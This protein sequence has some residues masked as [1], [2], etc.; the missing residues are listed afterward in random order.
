M[1]HSFQENNVSLTLW[2]ML[3]CL[4]RQRMD[5]SFLLA[6]GLGQ[7]PESAHRGRGRATEPCFNHDAQSS[8]IQEQPKAWGLG[9]FFLF[10]Q[11][12]SDKETLLNPPS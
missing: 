7:Q 6:P 4:E 11:Y 9:I 10:I 5:G 1:Q 3:M 8:F 12:N 2:S